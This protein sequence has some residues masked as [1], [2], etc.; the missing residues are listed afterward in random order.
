MLS[1]ENLHSPS[2]IMQHEPEIRCSLR[3]MYFCRVGSTLRSQSAQPQHPIRPTSAQPC[4]STAPHSGCRMQVSNMAGPTQL[5]Q[6]AVPTCACQHREMLL[7]VLRGES[8]K[9]IVAKF[10]AVS[11][12]TRLL[13][14]FGPDQLQRFR[15]ASQRIERRHGRGSHDALE[16]SQGE[17]R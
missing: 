7:L 8:S 5:A 9:L 4:G 10:R 14:G 6:P 16:G 13:P 11:V 1:W 2:K 3:M 12:V 17:G 15:I